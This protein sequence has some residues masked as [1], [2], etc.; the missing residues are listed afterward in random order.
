MSEEVIHETFGP[1]G[2]GASGTIQT[3]TVPVAG[4]YE[5]KGAG[6]EGGFLDGNGNPNGQ[7]ARGRVLLE[8]EEGEQLLILV[9][10]Q[11]LTGS[12][13]GGQAGGGGT[14]VCRVTDSG[15]YQMRAGEHADT[16][17]DPLLVL[18][19][20][21]GS[22]NSSSDWDPHGRADTRGVDT[23]STG[24]SNSSGGGGGG[25]FDLDGDGYSG[26]V[27]IA[28]LNG[29]QGGGSDAEGGFG[30]GGGKG[31]TY[32]DG[33][34]GGGWDGGDHSYEDTLGGGGSYTTAAAIEAEL[35]PGD[36][37]DGHHGDGF[38][39]ITRLTRSVAEMEP[40]DLSLDFAAQTPS[41][42]RVRW[43][44]S[45]LVEGIDHYQLR[46][47]EEPTAFLRKPEALD[48]NGD[49]INAKVSYA[50]LT[51]SAP[52]PAWGEVAVA[53]RFRLYSED[54]TEVL[55]TKETDTPATEVRVPAQPESQPYVVLP[56]PKSPPEGTAQRQGVPLACTSFRVAH[57]DATPEAAQWQITPAA[58]EPRWDDL[59]LGDTLTIE[60]HVYTP[61]GQSRSP[62][63]SVNDWDRDFTFYLRDEAGDWLRV[64]DNGSEVL[65]LSDPDGD[66]TSH[67]G[68]WIHLAV[69]FD[70][71]KVHVYRDGEHIG[72]AAHLGVQTSSSDP[73]RAGAY[74]PT[75]NEG[76]IED[77][78]LWSTARTQEQI[79]QDM[80]KGADLSGQPGLLWRVDYDYSATEPLS[81]EQYQQ[82]YDSGEVGDLEE[83][84]PTD[85]PLGDVLWRVR[86][87]DQ[88]HGWSAWSVLR[89]N[90][91]LE[92]EPHTPQ[93]LGPEG[94]SYSAYPTLRASEQSSNVEEPAVASRYRLYDEHG[95]LVYDS[96]EIAYTTRHAVPYEA[97]PADYREE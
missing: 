9:G 28:F 25:G 13:S 66:G 84:Q 91:L 3:W 40:D 7:G 21:A 74:G 76:E 81:V 24:H 43:D 55:Y 79:T 8:L 88:V 96:G 62:I 69:V 51:A 45:F 34:G 72:E 26:N 30:G 4:A 82:P 36:P 60:A 90:T 48:P 65:S 92:P 50:T 56:W 5:I 31:G 12:T 22:P 57:D 87:K 46:L 54:G 83:H 11:G 10:Q 16:Y 63:V 70:G 68:K 15:P 49:E 44:A 32:N 93:A 2:T 42:V 95:T 18:G 6:A 67:H 89:A 61:A 53:S 27:G 47:V 23:Q 73:L 17:L 19:G 39:E 85:P 1:T 52:D 64:Y 35:H 14:F 20:G 97:L 38:V 80:G 78:R 75:D 41:S 29:G 58:I 37:G 86:H 94:E 77:L 59:G 71:S 33:G